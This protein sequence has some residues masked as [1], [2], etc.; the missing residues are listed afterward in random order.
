ML[1]IIAIAY[2]LIAY[3][4]KKKRGKYLIHTYN[5]S[6]FGG[7]GITFYFV[8]SKIARIEYYEDVW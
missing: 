6:F 2:R 4:K 8:I 5:Y 3:N 1:G 7:H